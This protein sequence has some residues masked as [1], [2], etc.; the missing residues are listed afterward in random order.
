MN[1]LLFTT[2]I[3]YTFEEYKLFNQVLLKQRKMNYFFYVVI[4]LM[5]LKLW[6]IIIVAIKAENDWEPTG[7]LF[8]LLMLLLSFRALSSKGLERAWSS[9]GEADDVWYYGFFEDYMEQT[10]RKGMNRIYYAQL[11]EIIETE[12]HFYPMIGKNNGYII[13]KEN[14]RPELIAFLQEKA[15]ELDREK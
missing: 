15:R 5:G 13:R 14:C 6:T 11:Y 7:M 10:T 8:P 12:T 1:N 9:S 2:G 4:G 3:K